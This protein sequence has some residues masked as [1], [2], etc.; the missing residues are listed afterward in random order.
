MSK[1]F[2]DPLNS[3]FTGILLLILRIAVG[4]HFL[5]EGI[6]KLFS[7][8]WT[9]YDFL[10]MSDWLFSGIFHWIANNPLALEITD[11]LNIWGLII[12]GLA[13]FF[14]IFTRIAS[15]GGV[16]LLLLY[17]IANPPLIGMG[18]GAPAE[19]SYL[20]VNKNVIE[21]LILAVFMFLPEKSLPGIDRLFIY[22]KI[23][24]LRSKEDK[25][26]YKS[27]NV[28]G[29]KRREVIKNLA[30]LPFFGAFVIAAIKKKGWLSYE[31]KFLQ[32]T[33][34]DAVSS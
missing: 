24:Y 25:N 34:A 31:E 10:S 18:F 14:G 26:P 6:S 4:W 19:G 7:E 8:G 29:I 1:Y 30:A 13:L 15:C 22:L 3:G 2:K 5:Y 21:M 11:F 32:E 12:I 20:I 9:S 16:A 28:E 27:P 33:D 23:I 17:Y